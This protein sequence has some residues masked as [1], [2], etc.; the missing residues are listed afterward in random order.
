MAED[1]TEVTFSELI[2]VS[3][4]RE[5]LK[6]ALAHESPGPAASSVLQSVD[7]N[8]LR[9]RPPIMEY[10]LRGRRATADRGTNRYGQESVDQ[11]C[12]LLSYRLKATEKHAWKPGEPERLPPVSN[13]ETEDELS[14]DEVIL[15]VAIYEAERPKKSR[16]VLVLGSQPLSVLTERLSCISNTITSAEPAPI[17]AGFFFIE[18]TFYTLEEGAEHALIVKKFLTDHKIMWKTELN[19]IERE[20]ADTAVRAAPSMMYDSLK[21]A[22]MDRT[23]FEHLCIRLG[24]PYVFVHHNTMKHGIGRLRTFCRF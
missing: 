20:Q 9:E 11:D 21:M 24:F 23:R 3:N 12:R 7:L 5:E 4:F 10:V 17:G 6:I 19:T 2:D 13:K 1:V 16:E 15:Q 22:P 18:D 8:E 14:V